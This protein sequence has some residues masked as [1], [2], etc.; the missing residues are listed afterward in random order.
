MKNKKLVWVLCIAFLV[1][2][3]SMF[4]AL[5]SAKAEPPN[6]RYTKVSIDNTPLFVY[7]DTTTQCRFIYNSIS[8]EI[9]PAKGSESC[10]VPADFN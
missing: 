6:K 3:G 1:Y 5:S 2:M 4:A 9:R 8:R 7:T 10:T